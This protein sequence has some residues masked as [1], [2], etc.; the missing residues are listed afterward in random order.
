MTRDPRAV[1]LADQLQTEALEVGQA[2]FE[3]ALHSVEMC[4]SKFDER[5]LSL[6]NSA[7]ISGGTAMIDV[8]VRHD[9]IAPYGV[10]DE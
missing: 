5:L 10:T 1:F 6:L 8:L 7:I 9:R 3:E 2:L 4:S